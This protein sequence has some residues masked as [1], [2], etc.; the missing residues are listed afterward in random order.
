MKFRLIALAFA[1][2]A[3]PVFATT[4]ASVTTS[5]FDFVLKDLNAADGVTAG[6]TWDSSWN[7]YASSSYSQQTGYQLVSYSWGNSLESK[8][9]AQVSDWQSASAPATSLSSSAAGGLG[10]ISVSLDGSGRPA[11]SV[12]LSVGEGMSAYASAQFSRGF[13]LTAGTQ[14]SF[15]VLADSNLTGTGYAGSWTPPAG[16]NSFPGH[17][18]AN[19]SV[20]MSVGSLSGSLNLSGSNGFN[21]SQSA[22]ETVGEADQLKLII[23]NT[24]TTDQYYWLNTYAQVNVQEQLDPAT[25]ALV[26]EPGTYALMALG[27]LGVAGAARRRKA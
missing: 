13:W 19:A 18:W 2:L 15:S 16:V 3:S 27:L 10:S 12:Q 7:L 22:F 23:R 24:T 5:S 25:A 1:A 6:L 17:S 14:V 4:T 21:Y 20:G 26:P 11:A 9:G 8:F